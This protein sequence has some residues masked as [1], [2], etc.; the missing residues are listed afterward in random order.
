MN[1]DWDKVC[2]VVTAVTAIIALLISV[3]QMRLSNKQQLLNRR[4]RIWTRAQGLMELCD[5]ARSSLEKMSDDP[6]STNDLPNEALFQ[7]I[8]D[9]SVLYD[10]A[11]VEERPLEGWQPRVLAKLD[12]LREMAFEAELVFRGPAAEALGT[13]LK[14]YV[15]LLMLMYY[16]QIVLKGLREVAG[17]R[18]GDL[19]GATS[20]VGEE[21]ERA[22]L[23]E[24]RTKLLE[25]L[26]RLS[27]YMDKQLRNQCRLSLL[28]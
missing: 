7:A 27:L 10:I 1:I 23:N 2:T 8:A 14:D 24:A 19:D 12:E 26:D 28:S 11:P 6:A 3:V 21:G 17:E 5:D 25:S 9:R 13:F 18:H 20:A 22:K 4:V 15:S 16:Y